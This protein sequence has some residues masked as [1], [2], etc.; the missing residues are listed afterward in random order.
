MADSK[1]KGRTPASGAA[2]PEGSRQGNLLQLRGAALFER[3]TSK[4]W[5]GNRS[6]TSRSGFSRQGYVN[7][8]FLLSIKTSFLKRSLRMRRLL[9]AVVESNICEDASRKNSQRE[10]ELLPKGIGSFPLRSLPRSPWARSF[11]VGE[12]TREDRDDNEGKSAPFLESSI[13]PPC[14]RSNEMR[15][16]S[17]SAA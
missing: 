17:L 16:S 9:Q 12:L 7:F 10:W 4:G 6:F 13:P 5:D 3:G 1:Y 8:I 11:R 15:V 2:P 14:R